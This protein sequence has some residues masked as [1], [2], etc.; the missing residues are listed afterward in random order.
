MKNFECKNFLS[1]C[2]RWEELK[3]YE[4]GM[5]SILSKSQK[6]P[7]RNLKQ[8]LL[9]KVTNKKMIIVYLEFF[10]DFIKT[11]KTWEKDFKQ[12]YKSNYIESLPV[13]SNIFRIIYLKSNAGIGG[14]LITARRQVEKGFAY[15]YE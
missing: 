15:I 8:Y 10:N 3:I 2:N 9:K 13:S 6:I 1:L 12:R 7:I 11:Y 4:L 14:A 5:Q